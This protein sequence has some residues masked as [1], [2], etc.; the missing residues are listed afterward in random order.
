MAV[1]ETK[2]KSLIPISARVQGFNVFCDKIATFF[3]A[4]V[5]LIRITK[6]FLVRVGINH[7][8][9][10]Q[11]VILL[12]GGCVMYATIGDVDEH[13]VPAL[14]RIS[15]RNLP[16]VKMERKFAGSVSSLLTS[17]F[18]RFKRARDF[19]RLVPILAQSFQPSMIAHQLRV[20]NYSIDLS[21]GLLSD[22][23][24]IIL[25]DYEGEPVST[26]VIL[27]RNFYYIKQNA[28]KIG[29]TITP[30]KK[31]SFKNSFLR[32]K[33]GLI[34]VD[35]K[36]SLF[37]ISRQRK[38]YAVA[39]RRDDFDGEIEEKEYIPQPQWIYRVLRGRDWAILTTQN[40]EIELICRGLLKLR[41]KNGLWSTV[42]LSSF[43]DSF[44]IYSSDSKCAK[45]LLWL[46]EDLSARRK[47]ALFVI[48]DNSKIPEGLIE[49]R[50]DM[51]DSTLKGMLNIENAPTE[52][53]KNM[54][55]IDGAVILSKTGAI[56]ASGTHIR[57]HP[58]VKGRSVEGTRSAA[59]LSASY[60]GYAIKISRDGDVTAYNKG[61][62]M[63]HIE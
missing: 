47:G 42:P 5:S 51:V 27:T 46:I 50:K 54:S 45:K 62:I 56:L 57:P 33:R 10:K 32:T 44:R 25:R 17:Y 60:F 61:K 55:I 31:L 30:I 9:L 49:N 39:T 38:I 20:N 16:F 58:L 18:T 26:G 4:R 28:E 3:N 40:R 1:K 22:F 63:F 15:R 43:F 12:N 2:F 23:Q 7:K 36:N 53:I 11:N 14:I 21:L 29:I 8:Q 13:M 41:Y 34:L 6:S 24:R 19:E 37:V 59:A 52:I 35:G 48:V